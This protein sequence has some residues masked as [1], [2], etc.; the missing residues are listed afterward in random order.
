M[1]SEKVR[2]EDY[3]AV[4]LAGIITFVAAL[5]GGSFAS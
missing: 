1:K 2:N 4:L 3:Y 5:L